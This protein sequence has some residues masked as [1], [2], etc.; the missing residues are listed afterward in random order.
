MTRRAERRALPSARRYSP[1]I[2]RPCNRSSRRW[3]PVRSPRENR[4]DVESNRDSEMRSAEQPCRDQRRDGVCMR[5]GQTV[6]SPDGVVPRG[7]SCGFAGQNLRI[8]VG[9]R[10]PNGWRRPEFSA[11]NVSRV[12][13]GRRHRR[14]TSPQR[15]RSPPVEDRFHDDAAQS[16]LV[17][18]VRALRSIPRPV[19]RAGAPAPF[20]GRDASGS[21]AAIFNAAR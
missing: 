18:L 14:Y 5:H 9:F 12:T 7:P 8:P 6:A 21:P 3:P 11:W 16:V 13:R 17:V 19:S 2:S 10:C 4:D 20:L 1:E 15:S